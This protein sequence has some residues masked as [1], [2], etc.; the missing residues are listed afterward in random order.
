MAGRPHAGQL[1]PGV[2]TAQLHQPPRW[3]QVSD[4]PPLL[5]LPRIEHSPAPPR[6]PNH[7]SFPLPSRPFL[8]RESSIRK[9]KPSSSSSSPALQLRLQCSCLRLCPLPRQLVFYML[10]FFFSSSFVTPCACFCTQG[11]LA[12]RHAILGTHFQ[13][14]LF[15]NGLPASNRS[16][17]AKSD[18]AR[19]DQTCHMVLGSLGLGAIDA[20]AEP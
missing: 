10:L 14:S 7:P 1:R 12:V 6:G 16:D 20:L 18:Q 4:Y 13:V 2:P 5:Y 8:L 3:F 9:G 11:W 19:P 17:W 15:S